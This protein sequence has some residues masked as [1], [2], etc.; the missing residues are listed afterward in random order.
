MSVVSELSHIHVE[1]KSAEER[2]VRRAAGR[3]N[4]AGCLYSLPWLTGL[5]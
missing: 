1:A 4:E 2:R 3:D 5:S